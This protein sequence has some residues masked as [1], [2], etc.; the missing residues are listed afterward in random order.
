VERGSAYGGYWFDWLFARVL[1]REAL[2][3]IE[4]VETGPAIQRD[5]AGTP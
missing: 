4:G 3:E 2:A 5:T 1:L